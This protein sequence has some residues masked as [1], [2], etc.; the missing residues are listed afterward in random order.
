M[1]IILTDE[2][3]NRKKG[4]VMNL[5]EPMALS[6]IS[7]GVAKAFV[8]KTGVKRLVKTRMVETAPVEK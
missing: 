1:K 2:W 8:E 7:R 5:T 4:T 6:L 3:M